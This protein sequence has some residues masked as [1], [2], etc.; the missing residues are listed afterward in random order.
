MPG[1][2]R[3]GSVLT[4]YQPSER[5]S[6]RAISSLWFPLGDGDHALVEAAP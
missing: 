1:W 2:T 3:L 4:L 6:A 5:N